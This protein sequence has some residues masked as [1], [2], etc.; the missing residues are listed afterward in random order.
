MVRKTE[1][2]PVLDDVLRYAAELRA[3]RQQFKN[4]AAS[5]PSYKPYDHVWA[6]SDEQARALVRRLGA[7]RALEDI[8]YRAQLS[9][10]QLE[11]HEDIE[12]RRLERERRRREQERRDREEL[13]AGESP[14]TRINRA[15][16]ALLVVAEGRAQNFGETINGGGEH[17]PAP[18]DHGDDEYAR[19]CHV[20]LQ[21]ARRIEALQERAQRAPLP[22]PKVGNRD[23]Q[24]RAMRGYSPE[25][26]AVMAPVQGTP[27][28]IRERREE[29]NL[30]PL[31]G[32]EVEA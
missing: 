4:P 20:A 24:L 17:A 16:A 7:P 11:I 9:I 19:A 31:T 6:P 27:R 18:I 13:A 2:E 21:A 32:D 5:N 12:R 26:V 15:L 25:Q 28:Q 23:E 14:G 29:M 8:K 22:P 3:N 30:D 10:D 1:R